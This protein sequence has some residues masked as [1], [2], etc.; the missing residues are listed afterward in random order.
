MKGKNRR[1]FLIFLSK[2]I[3]SMLVKPVITRSTHQGFA[4]KAFKLACTAMALTLLVESVLADC[5]SSILSGD[6]NSPIEL[7]DTNLKNDP[8][9][10]KALLLITNSALRQAQQSCQRGMAELCKIADFNGKAKA[11][12]ECYAGISPPS[13]TSAQQATTVNGQVARAGTTTSQSRQPECQCGSGYI[14][15][16]AAQAKAAGVQYTLSSSNGWD[17]IAFYEKSGAHFGGKGWHRG[18]NRCSAAVK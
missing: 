13:M 15:C 14:A 10:A 6:I 9:Y 2:E 8:A 12:L 1:A 16:H 3:E 4:M 5:P 17:N 18:E 11:G 7:V